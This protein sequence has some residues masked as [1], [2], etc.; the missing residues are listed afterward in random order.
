MGNP[1]PGSK[2]TRLMA[3]SPVDGSASAVAK[4]IASKLI[5][6]GM[7]SSAAGVASCATAS[8]WSERSTPTRRMNNLLTSRAVTHLATTGADMQVPDP[9]LCFRLSAIGYQPAVILAEPPELPGYWLSDGSTS[10]I[11]LPTSDPTCRLAVLNRGDGPHRP[12]VC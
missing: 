6:S 9:A 4:A 10:D 3:S 2:L 1:V 8:G 5:P 11:R 7:N 12:G